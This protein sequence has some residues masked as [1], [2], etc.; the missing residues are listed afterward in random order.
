MGHRPQL[1]TQLLEVPAP[2]FCSVTLSF[3]V[4]KPD[5][6]PSRLA[7]SNQEKKMIFLV[8]FLSSAGEMFVV[9]PKDQLQSG[10]GRSIQEVPSLSWVSCY[11]KGSRFQLPF[12]AN[13]ICG[14]TGSRDCVWIHSVT[15]HSHPGIENV[16]PG[17]RTWVAE[18]KLVSISLLGGEGVPLAAASA[19]PQVPHISSSRRPSHHA[20]A[21]F[22]HLS[23]GAAF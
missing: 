16:A 19:W 22:S 20:W 1:C 2:E 6:A 13:P 10:V 8:P 3:P 17:K 5:E 7:N 12:A 11:P 23:S 4:A 21:P 9:C 15:Q 14:C 18:A